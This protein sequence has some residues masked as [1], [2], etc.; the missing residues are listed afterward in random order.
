MAPL[1]GDR[2]LSARRFVANI[3]AAGWLAERDIQT[4]EVLFVSWRRSGPFVRGEV[5][6]R[7]LD[8]SRDA[9]ATLFAVPG[10]LP[11]EWREVVDAIA[12]VVARLHA[13]G[14]IHHDLNFRNFLLTG[15]GEVM[16][17]D[18]DKVSCRQLSRRARERNLARLERSIR[19]VARPTHGELSEIVVARLRESYAARA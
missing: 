15:A 7:R 12:Q 13:T 8:G 17:L 2:F 3:E 4:P 14:I 10:R 9:A 1:T 19:K 16:V 18:L 11:G 6:T 5:A